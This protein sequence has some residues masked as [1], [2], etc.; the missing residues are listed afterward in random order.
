MG[1]IH[2]SHLRTIMRLDNEEERNK[3]LGYYKR[4]LSTQFPDKT[5]ENQK[6]LLEMGKG[7]RVDTD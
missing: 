6:F 4:I 1:K 7:K 2:W 5:G 3:K